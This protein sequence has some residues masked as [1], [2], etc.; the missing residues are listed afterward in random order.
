MK[1]AQAEFD[2]INRDTEDERRE[3]RA[4]REAVRNQLDRGNTPKAAPPPPGVS[5][6]DRVGKPTV[7]TT[8]GGSRVTR[9]D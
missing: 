3:L 5:Q 7:M 1:D 4:R 8:A 2:R 6:R 9:V